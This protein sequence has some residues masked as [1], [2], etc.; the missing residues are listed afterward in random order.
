MM[1]SGTK[2]TSNKP[3]GPQEFAPLPKGTVKY[4]FK[5]MQR[6]AT[7]HAN[8]VYNAQCT[9]DWRPHEENRVPL[10]TFSYQRALSF[11]F[12]FLATRPSQ[13]PDAG[14]SVT[15]LDD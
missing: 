15:Y 14:H 13:E 6:E 8:R 3:C 11:V 9:H 1:G 10:Q 7:H 2:P 4:T 5:Y 12:Q